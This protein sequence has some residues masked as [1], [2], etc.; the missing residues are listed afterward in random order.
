MLPAL[1]LQDGSKVKNTLNP[2]SGPLKPADVVEGITAAQQNARRLL[3]D[4]KLLLEA[5]RFPSSA[6][7][8]ILSIEERGKSILLKRLALLSKPDELKA[9]WREYRNHR[10]KNAGWIIPSLVMD[11][12]RTMHGMATAID[13][14]A[15]HAALLDALKQISLYTDCLGKAHWSIP[16]DVIDEELARSLVASAELMWGGH[17]VTVREIELWSEIVGPHY[18]LG[19][20]REAVV[21][22]QTVMHKEG[23]SDVLPEALEAFMRGA[24]IEMRKPTT[25]HSGQ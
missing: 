11:G 5:G 15:E 23:L 1:V 3:D 22:W 4:A 6:A 24:P 2:Y 12:V 17:S 20:M 10:A 19:S 21:Q 7:L 8:A 18:N 13:P 16:N 25:K 14:N 9:T